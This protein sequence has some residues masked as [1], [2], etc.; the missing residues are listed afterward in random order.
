MR[1]WKITLLVILLIGIF[2]GRTQAEVITIFDSNAVIAGGNTYD[3]V[4]VKGDSTVVDMTGGDVNSVIVMDS[5]TFNMSGGNIGLTIGGS[6][7]SYDSAVLNLSAGNIY[8]IMSYGQSRVNISGNVSIY[9]ASSGF[10][11]STL[12]TMSSEA[13]AIAGMFELYDTSGLNLSA[14]LLGG[15]YDRGDNATINITGGNTSLYINGRTNISG[16]TVNT[17]TIGGG[18][19]VVRISGGTIGS[20]QNG[21]FSH[22]SEV[23]IIG[24]D[25][26]AVPYGGDYGHG[27]ITGNFNDDSAFS[28]PLWGFG[29]YPIVVLYDGV[30]PA[31]CTDKPKSDL[32]NDCKVNF[33]DISNVASEW[34]DC[35]L[36]PQTACRE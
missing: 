29:T 9:A 30:I 33:V 24:Y 15:V 1:K 35:G 10:Y 21:V 12:V 32:N 31:D 2:A 11:G 7:L 19:T 17:V 8:S 13:T 22:T 20:I 34:L 6:L 23:S 4:V 5:S 28:I 36:T 27:Q 25:L 18:E 26:T 16:G 3:T 14:G